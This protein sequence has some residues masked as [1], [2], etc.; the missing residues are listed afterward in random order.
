MKAIYG[1]TTL[2]VALALALSTCAA[3]GI[4]DIPDRIGEWRVEVVPEGNDYFIGFGY[5]LDKDTGKLLPPS[6]EIMRHVRLMAP[7]AEKMRWEY[8]PGDSTYWI[9]AENTATTE[10][11]AF[12]F[13]RSGDFVRLDYENKARR[14][15]EEADEMTLPGRRWEIGMTE[16][17][18]GALDVLRQ[19]MGGQR[20]TKAWA[21][22]TQHGP[23]YLVQIGE[24]GVFITPEGA[25]RCADDMEAALE[26]Y[27]PRRGIG[28]GKLS[29]QDRMAEIRAQLG[30]YGDRFHFKRIIKELGDGPKTPDGSYRYIVMGDTRSNEE[31][32]NA[33]IQH[34]NRLEPKPDFILNS[35]DLVPTGYPY[36]WKNY[37]LPTMLNSKVPMLVAIGN[38]D[39]EEGMAETYQFLFGEESLD[40]YFDYGKDRYIF[41]D[42]VTDVEDYH[43]TLK[44]LDWVLAE[45]PPGYRKYVMAHSPPKNIMKWAH[46]A[47]STEHSPIWTDL[48][49][50]HDVDHVYLGHIHAYSTTTFGGVDYTVSGGGG[51]SLKPHFGPQGQAYHYIICDVTRNRVTRHVVRFYEAN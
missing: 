1:A 41:F 8:D 22:E 7:D 32:W 13:T 19:V 5:A 6:A 47:W 15:E 16:T 25:I 31:V 2:A 44:W 3:P 39:D 27:E 12:D 38:H 28:T 23:R 10:A 51:A 9:E 48:M 30:E 36:Q 45:T 35:G 4:P 43:Q 21:T 20:P 24:L 46:H 40:Y 33:I 26:F 14:R 50:K 42:N 49:T 18:H 29:P 17:P 34:I 37:W 11:Y